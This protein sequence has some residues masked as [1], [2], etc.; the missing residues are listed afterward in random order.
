MPELNKEAAA[1]S[2]EKLEALHEQVNA[3][4]ETPLPVESDAWPLPGEA[5]IAPG[6]PAETLPPPT[7]AV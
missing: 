7:P 5:A 1:P 3:M 2:P 6:T 4:L